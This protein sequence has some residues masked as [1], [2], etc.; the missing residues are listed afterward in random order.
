MNQGN[1]VVGFL[2]LAALAAAYPVAA[3][4]IFGL[5]A[6]EVLF[7]RVLPLAVRAARNRAQ[8]FQY[9]PE[10]EQSL[11]RGSQ[12]F[13]LMAL[14]VLA[15]LAPHVWLF[16]WRD[17]AGIVARPVE[18]WP[19]LLCGGLFLVG[20]V[21]FGVGVRRSVGARDGMRWCKA[22]LRCGVGVV[23]LVCLVRADLPARIEPPLGGLVAAAAFA[24]PLWLALT[25]F[26]RLVL[27]TVGGSSAERRINRLMKERNA[28]LLPSR[29]RR[30][31][32]F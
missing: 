2:L 30:F 7:R 1:W 29:P 8:R 9:L 32:F 13:A 14:S 15:V 10:L 16:G 4:V 20:A 6:V 31:L 3:A 22:A 27:L 21:R 26:M 19:L 24:V 12:G 25:G 23:A 5:I 17:F 18:F 28:A 11:R